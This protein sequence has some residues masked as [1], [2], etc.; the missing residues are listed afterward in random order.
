MKNSLV[1]SEKN[2]PS[3]QKS[4]VTVYNKHSYEIIDVP[5]KKSNKFFIIL[6]VVVSILSLAFASYQFF[7]TDSSIPVAVNTDK[8]TS[9]N[10]SEKLVN[11]LP[12]TENVSKSEDCKKYGLIVNKGS[13][14]KGK[15]TNFWFEVKDP[16]SGQVTRLNNQ[17]E[18]VWFYSE[19]GFTEMCLSK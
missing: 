8:S 10:D 1:K 4:N 9:P 15:D 6:I 13:E 14:K 19:V 11:D 3:V 18:T 12:P 16:Q 5:R 17:H 7:S 2:L